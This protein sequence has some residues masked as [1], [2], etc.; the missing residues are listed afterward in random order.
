MRKPALI[1]AIEDTLTSGAMPREWPLVA[2]GNWGVGRPCALC[3]VEIGADQVEVEALFRDHDPHAFHVR[4]FVRWW[5]T[6]EATRP[7]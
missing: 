2:G 7:A 6:V 3:R 4:C 1:E 5:R